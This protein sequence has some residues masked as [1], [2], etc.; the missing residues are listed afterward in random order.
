MA[1]HARHESGQVGRAVRHE[2]VKAGVDRGHEERRGHALARDVGHAERRAA[3]RRAGRRR[4]SRRRPASSAGSRRPRG[5]PAPPGASRGES[6]SGWRRRARS[7]AP[8]SPS[9]P[10]RGAGA[11]SRARSRP[12]SQRAIATRSSASV[13]SSIEPSRFSLSAT[14]RTPSQ[15]P[16]ARIGTARSFSAGAF[17]SRP[18]RS[19]IV[20]QRSDVDGSSRA[21]SPSSSGSPRWRTVT[22]AVRSAVAHDEGSRARVEERDRLVENVLGQQLEVEGARDGEADVVE[23]LQLPDPVLQLEVRLLH[24][25][26]HPHRVEEARRVGRDRREA[27]RLRGALF[28]QESRERLLASGDRDRDRRVPGRSRQPDPACARDPRGPLARRAP[29]S[30]ERRESR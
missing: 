17:T 12:D 9:R 3:V 22:G 14:M 25:V 13:K 26:R 15:R 5:A 30:G 23:A 4:S 27:D 10:P 20:L 1:V 24:L 11:R 28:E 8:S 18:T 2:E 19:A 6:S 7:P 16:S 29:P 21:D